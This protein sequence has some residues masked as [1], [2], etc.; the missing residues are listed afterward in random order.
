MNRRLS[1][2]L[3][4]LV[5]LSVVSSA[6]TIRIEKGHSGYIKGGFLGATSKGF[7]VKFCYAMTIMDKYT[8]TIE[9]GSFLSCS[10]DEAIIIESDD[11]LSLKVLKKASSRL[12]Q[13]L[14]FGWRSVIQWQPS[15]RMNSLLQ[16][17]NP[18]SSFIFYYLLF[19]ITDFSTGVQILPTL[20]NSQSIQESVFN[21]QILPYSLLIISNT[22][23]FNEKDAFLYLGNKR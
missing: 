15:P 20:L 16:S 13:I 18:P 10:Q 21:N 23:N 14:L 6:F 22:N 8:Y 3:L 4:P 12:M 7:A 1:V 17:S 2:L 9:P 19:G 11:G 5:F